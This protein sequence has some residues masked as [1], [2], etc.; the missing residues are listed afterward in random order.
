[1]IVV[2]YRG[3]L[4]MFE[5]LALGVRDVDVETGTIRVRHGKG[6]RSRIVGID[7]AAGSLLG[8][9]IEVRGA[10]GIPRSAPLF[11]TL[12]GRRLHDRYV[13]ALLRSR[14]PTAV[15]RRLGRSDGVGSP[16]A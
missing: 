10:R 16:E 1:L 4:R 2:L 8:R 3:G 12:G 6:D 5:A 7:P 9:W 13:R 11:C 14:L 15:N